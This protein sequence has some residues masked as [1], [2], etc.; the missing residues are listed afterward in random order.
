M[1]MNCSVPWPVSTF[2]VSRLGLEVTKEIYDKKEDGEWSA[3]FRPS[4]FF[5]KYK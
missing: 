5:Q 2:H 3:L 4:N 1:C